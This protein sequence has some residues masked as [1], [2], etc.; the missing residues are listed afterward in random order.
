M[1]RNYFTIAWRNLVR[2][3]VYSFINIVGLAI[4]MTCFI[5]IALFIQYELSYDTGHEKAGQIYR[6]AQRQKGNEFRGTDLFAKTPAAMAPTL[7]AEFPEVEVATTVQ[8]HKVLLAKENKVFSEQGLFTDE[9][10]FDVFTFPLIEGAGKE[11]LKDPNTIILTLSLAKKYFPHENPIGKTLLFG[12]EHPLTVRGIIADIPENQHFTFD[13]I[14][15]YK[16]YPYYEGNRNTWNSNNYLTYVV[17]QDGYNY[18]EFEKKLVSLDKYLGSYKGLPFTPSF[19]LQPLLSIHL[20]SHVNFEMGANGN[21][22]YVYIFASIAFVILL[23]ASINYTNLTT[24]QS[25]RRAKEVGM[26]KV[27]GAERSQLVYQL[28]GESLLLTLISFV[29]ALVLANLLLPAFNQLL[30]QTISFGAIGTPWILVVMLIAAL[31]ISGLSGIYPAVYLSALAPIQA[32]KGGFMKS[33]KQGISLR[34]M[35]V[36]GQFAASIVLAI[37]SVVI[38]QQLGYIQNKELG[39]SREQIVYVPYHDVDITQ[40]IPAIRAALLSNP[41]IEK[42]TFPV[43]MPL[44]MISET[45]VK[46]WEGNDSQGDFFVYNNYVDYDF[47]DLFEITLKEGRNFSPD[48]PTD[49][50]DSYILNESA[51]KALGWES[52]IGKQFRGGKIIGVVKDFHFQP[53]GLAIKPL[54]LALRKGRGAMNTEHI[55]IKLKT[56]DLENTLAAIGQTI[57][58]FVPHIPFEYRFMD[59]AYAQLYQSEQRL[60]QAFT[61]F[62]LLALFIAC[63]GLLGLVSQQVMQR[64]KEIGIR[65][66]LGASVP[67]IVFLLSKDFLKLVVLALLIAVPLAWY[68]MSRWLEDFA[69]SIDLSWWMFGLAGVVALAIAL[70][71]VSFQSIKAA[72][73]NP[74]KSLRSE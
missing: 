44:N 51:V 37:G 33:Y 48:Y 23:L 70:I 64:T 69:Y 25:A 6:V 43:Y 24:A 41:R 74:V 12:N 34:N 28:L 7:E 16:N 3:K 10:V 61:I 35:L 57:K 26:R 40:K 30:D 60:G 5:L 36:V 39:Y 32:L 62:T 14:T 11:A 63:M 73:A 71:T 50:V 8:V 49:S 59:E 52:A 4:G 46:D 19:F 53:L 54:F 38:Y 17:L 68:A 21:I 29:L 72:L 47:I 13:Y 22:R 56:G 1:L 9:H 15:S 67:G 2:N 18:R 31:L 27:I 58:N 45:I 42:V 65:K 66:V 55:A 20:Y